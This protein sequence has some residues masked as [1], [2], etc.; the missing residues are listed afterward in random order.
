MHPQLLQLIE[1]GPGHPRPS[2]QVDGTAGDDQQDLLGALG[3]GLAGR[4][5]E[6]EVAAHAGPVRHQAEP[7]L[8]GHGHGQARPLRGLPRERPHAAERALE[9]GASLLAQW[10]DGFLGPQALFAHAAR[11]PWRDPVDQ[12]GIV[13]PHF[14]ARRV[15]AAERPP[16]GGAARSMPLDP[17]HHLGVR[18]AGGQVAHGRASGGGDPLGDLALAAADA[19]EDQDQGHQPPCP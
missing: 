8:L 6:V 12:Q 3:Q 14:G 7:A 15:V 1:V 9:G 16:A 17:L 13:R 10:G 4:P 11:E 5:G 19:P 2:R 18:A